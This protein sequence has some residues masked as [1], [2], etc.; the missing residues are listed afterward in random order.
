MSP[1][2][3][4]KKAIRRGQER[5]GKIR[6][7][8]HVRRK[9]IHKLEHPPKPKP[10]HPIAMFDSVSV[11][12]IPKSAP[13]V[14]GYVGGAWPTFSE[15]PAA[16]PHAY[17]MSIAVGSSET[18]LCLD[19][20]P[21]DANNASAVGWAKKELVRRP[22]TWVYTSVSNVDALLATLAAGGVD[23]SKVLI[24]SA[25]YTFHP[26]LCGPASCGECRHLCDAT[27]WT[28]HAGGGDLDQSLV[29]GH[30]IQHLIAPGTVR[31]P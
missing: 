15:L 25:H 5:I 14:A 6:D 2:G 11:A 10:P 30:A 19:V 23:T 13:A 20:E 9:K 31:H 12:A 26:H 7:R 16:F 21:G 22:V 1:I 4:L 18:A 27:Q 3:K 24:W 29:G 8:D 17:L 28:D